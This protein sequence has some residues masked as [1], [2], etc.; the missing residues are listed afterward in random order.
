MRRALQASLCGLLLL[1]LAG[2]ARGPDQAGLQADVQRQLDALFGGRMLEVRSIRRQGSAPLAA[3]GDG[4]SQAIV[5]FNA[6]LAF[7]APYDPSDWSGLSPEL[8]AS[9]L[10]ATDEGVIGLGAGRIGQGTPLRAYGSMVY[11]RAGKEAWQPSLLPPADALSQSAAKVPDRSTALIER[12]ADI[13]NTTPG[14]HEADDA[15]VAQELDQALQNIR[16]R[17]N[18]GDQE[19]LLVASGPTGGEYMRFVESLRP[20]GMKW[21]VTQATTAGSVDNALML[22]AGEARFGLVQSDVAAAAVTGQAAFEAHGPM[23]HLRAVTALFPEPVHVVVRTDGGAT[24]I[25][26]LRGRRIALGSRGSGTRQTAIQV[27]RAH[28]LDVADYVAADAGNPDEALRLLADGGIDA[29]VEVVSAPWSQLAAVAA[30]TP[31]TLLPLDPAAVAQLAGNLPGLVP[32]SIPDRT[33]GWQRGNVPTVAATALLVANASVPDEAVR[34]V[35]EFFYESDRAVERG[36]SASRLSR[37]RALVGVTIPLHDGAAD[38]FAA[39][40]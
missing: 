28:G 27:L 37:E 9:A 34:R 13:V 3:A 11:R 31:L 36:A 23:R 29:V 20:R 24:T 26:G 12:L 33:Y 14:L 2:C 25:A 32:L 7:T 5:Y 39:S 15:I 19:Q 17:L 30:K 40:K 35:L 38:Y 18:R 21:A 4:A 8:I 6:V 16:L 1:V 10:G 22:D